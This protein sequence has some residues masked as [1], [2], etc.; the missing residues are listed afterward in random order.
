MKATLRLL[1]LAMLALATTFI[2]SCG[3][4]PISINDRLA[5]FAASLNGNRSD[6]YTDC[7]PNATD[8]S[9]SKTPNFWNGAFPTAGGPYSVTNVNTS[10][11][12]A[13]LTMNNG[14]GP[15]G[16]YTFAMVNSPNMG[17]DNWLISKITDPT[18][19]VVFQ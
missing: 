8:Y 13:T 4:P 6:T 19:F 3:P 2:L 17:S 16:T 9:P 11:S 5:D 7:D 12:T 15:L 14:S 1:L 18:S 10:G